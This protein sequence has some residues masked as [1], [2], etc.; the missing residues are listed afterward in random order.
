MS[1]T[2]S[3]DFAERYNNIPDPRDAL[4]I[5][6]FDRIYPTKGCQPVSPSL[7]GLEANETTYIAYISDSLS[8]FLDT[9]QK[10]QNEL[11]EPFGQYR[12]SNDMSKVVEGIAQFFSAKNRLYAT[13][14]TNEEYRHHAITGSKYIPPPLSSSSACWT[15][16]RETLL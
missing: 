8:G 1:R 15:V 11:L 10:S 9:E 4:V 12:C 3:E 13:T 6:E 16:L 2:L 14:G 5:P 7:L